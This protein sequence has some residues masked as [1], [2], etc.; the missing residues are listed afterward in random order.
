MDN[1]MEKMLYNFV[2]FSICSKLT[3]LAFSLCLAICF[4]FAENCLFESFAQFYIWFF[5]FLP[6]TLVCRSSLYWWN[7]SSI[8]H[9]FSVFSLYF[10]LICDS[11]HQKFL[12][13]MCTLF[14]SCVMLRKDLFWKMNTF[15]YTNLKC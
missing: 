9:I 3:R 13:A 7:Y 5:F 2:V 11:H 6:F 1:L 14:R 15:S 4:H 8:Y 10:Y 12:N